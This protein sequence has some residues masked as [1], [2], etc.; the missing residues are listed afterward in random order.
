MIV[1]VKLLLASIILSP[2]MY[3]HEVRV[4]KTIWSQVILVNRELP[5]KLN[6]IIDFEVSISTNEFKVSFPSA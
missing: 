2:F 3:V 4:K 6:I 5:Q 1:T